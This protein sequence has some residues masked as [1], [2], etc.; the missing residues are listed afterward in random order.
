MTLPTQNEWLF[1]LKTFA[2]AMLAL[3]IGFW[4]DL[5]R[6]YWAMATVY[7]ASQ[8]QAGTTRAKAV[9]RLM[10][11][12]IGAAAAVALV[13]N[14]VDAPVLLVA[15]LAAWLTTCLSLSLLDRTP[16]GYVFMLAGYTAAIIGFPSVGSP[17]TIWDTALARTEEISLGIVCA[18]LVSI[19]V[20]P[21]HV[22]PIIAQRT[23]G[24]LAQGRPWTIDVLGQVEMSDAARADR[25]RLAADIIDIGVLADQLR[26]DPVDQRACADAARALHGRLLMLLPL[27]NSIAS[28]LA[29]MHAAEAVPA[30][31]AALLADTAAPIRSAGDTQDFAALRSRIAALQAQAD[32]SSAWRDIMAVGL[33]MRLRELV[34]LF[35]D[36]LALQ[37]HIKAG[38][39]HLPPLAGTQQIEAGTLQHRDGF[40]ALFSGVSAGVAVLTVCAFWIGAAW[41]EG[42]IAAE[43]TAVA[44]CFFAAQ[45]DPSPAILQFMRWTAVAIVI[46]AIYLFAIMP[47]IDG[48]PL[49]IAVLA[50]AF[51]FF[52]LLMARPARAPIGMALG[53]NG[54]TLL[55]LQG[56]YSADFP[57]FANG[58]VAT[59]L[60]MSAAAVITGLIRSVGADW[61]TWRLIRAN[62]ASLAEA[63]VQRGRGDRASVAG[64][65][66]DRIGL[67]AQR[68][69]K[70]SPEQAP[71]TAKLQADLRIGLNI[72]DLRRARHDLPAQAVRALDDVL[73]GLAVHYRALVHGPL[74]QPAWDAEPGLLARLDR[75]IGV[76]ACV[77]ACAARQDGLLGVV[78]MRT[79]LFPQAAPYAPAPPPFHMRQAA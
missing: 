34:D 28:R 46:D 54:A 25:R 8:A 48:F 33:L 18:T 66:L 41:T 53:V 70:L 29:V 4:A 35:G 37:A 69:G 38:R 7:I 77:P 79:A 21:R 49:L 2:A 32:R 45:D 30:A 23:A 11:T 76:L 44:C 51:V 10:G 61:S 52:G 72:V 20:V 17:G 12:V 73:D 36:S 26:Y 57:S 62:W 78:G 65:M 39:R 19:L 14:L 13:P 3:G 60:G 68:L 42:A 16:R 63:A 31:L 56:N 50:P 64:L 6:P 27:L 55:A 67:V 15:A 47:A 22:A 24:W 43:M 59:I 40:M 58:A 9:F 74:I 1:A 75:A 5:D 71:N